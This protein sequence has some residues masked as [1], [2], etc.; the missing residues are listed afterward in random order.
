MRHQRSPVPR[1]NVVRNV[2]APCETRC[3]KKFDHLRARASHA[4][5][6]DRPGRLGLRLLGSLG[7]LRA[8]ADSGGMAASR[9]ILESSLY[10]GARRSCRPHASRS[11]RLTARPR[12]LRLG[13]GDRLRAK[14]PAEL[15]ESALPSALTRSRAAERITDGDLFFAEDLD[16]AQALV[17]RGE[18]APRI[19][20]R[21]CLTP[22]GQEC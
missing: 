13:F 7:R 9:V 8:S 11:S 5:S 4:S 22:P 12:P 18:R 20:P 3:E 1:A 6:S 16:A 21:S 19:G 17:Q 2:D 15:Q 14:K 10:I